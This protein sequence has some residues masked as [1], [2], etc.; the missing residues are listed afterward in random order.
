M[1]QKIVIKINV[2]QLIHNVRLIAVL[3]VIKLMLKIIELVVKHIEIVIR[4]K[5]EQNCD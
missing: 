1:V 2:L 5:L 4:K 3:K